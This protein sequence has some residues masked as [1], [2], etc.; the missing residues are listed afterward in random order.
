MA[1]FDH[2]KG[3]KDPKIRPKSKVRAEKLRKPKYSPF[4]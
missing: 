3:Q 4:K 1:E 2:P